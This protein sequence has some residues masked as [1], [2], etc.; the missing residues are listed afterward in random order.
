MV[1]LLL[2]HEAELDFQDNRGWS[3]MMI[4]AHRSASLSIHAV[5]LRRRKLVR[6]T[7]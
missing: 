5:V 4:A 7:G 1:Q 6:N 3:A 2:D